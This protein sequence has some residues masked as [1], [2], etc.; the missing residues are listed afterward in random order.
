MAR[1]RA[2]LTG[3][4]VA[5]CSF[6]TRGRLSSLRDFRHAQVLVHAFARLNGLSR[7][8]G[9]VNFPVHFRG[10]AQVG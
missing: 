7:T 2:T 6:G 3:L 5:L 8:D 9:T 1:F 4:A 10:F